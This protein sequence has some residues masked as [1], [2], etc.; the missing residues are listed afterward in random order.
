[1]QQQ[2]SSRQTTGSGCS[3]SSKSGVRRDH[4][5]ACTTTLSSTP[6][7]ELQAVRLAI[8]RLSACTAGSVC[9]S[10]AAGSRQP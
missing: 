8:F 9:S 4:N 5:T 10:G 7:K 2:N 1:M 3:T 6:A